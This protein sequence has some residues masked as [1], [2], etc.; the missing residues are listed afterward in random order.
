VKL[1][2][3]A[4]DRVRVSGVRGEPAPSRLKVCIN[5]HGGFR[6][7]V[8]FLLTGLDIPEKARLAEDTFF[9]LVGGREQF[10]ETTVTLRRSDRE[11][12][13]TNEDA[14]ALLTIAV[15]DPDAKKVG[16]AFSGKSIEMALASY[17]GFKTAGLPAAEQ[18][19]GVYWPALVDARAVPHRVVMDDG[20]TL[21]VPRA[22]DAQRFEPIPECAP[23]A[24]APYS[25]PVHEL[26]LGR[27]C[28]TRSG[29]KGGNA[30][31]GVWVETPEAYRWL[32][33]FL[34]IA[35][36][37]ELLPETAELD[38]ERYTLPCVLALNF[39]IKRLL[40]DGVAASLRSDPQAKT[41]G[42]YLR[43]RVVAIP[44]SLALPRR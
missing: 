26:P 4:E 13:T 43:A 40:G 8:A 18:Q 42:E 3:E 5:H 9:H 16:R 11:D 17:P 23:P 32:E 35:R 19:F 20:T 12:P 1:E 34:T 37:R 6:N 39:V 22:P 28:G 21:D 29:D 2:Q 44:A 31:I 33:D 7:S 15:K 36:L 25:G 41:L 38:V 10:A 14:F 27:L 30:N 24:V